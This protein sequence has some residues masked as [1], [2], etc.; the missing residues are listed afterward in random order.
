LREIMADFL[1]ICKIMCSRYSHRASQRVARRG[2]VW[3]LPGS[4]RDAQRGELLKK[5]RESRGGRLG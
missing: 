2:F 3:V 5:D 1:G 4:V